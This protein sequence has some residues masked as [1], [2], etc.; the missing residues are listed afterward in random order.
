MQELEEQLGEQKKLLLSVASRG[1]EILSQR[2]TPNGDRSVLFTCPLSTC[3]DLSLAHYN[4]SSKK[5]G[6]PV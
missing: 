6:Q 2:T 5:T 4:C 3:S 1:E